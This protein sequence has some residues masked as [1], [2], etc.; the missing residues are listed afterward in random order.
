MPCPTALQEGAPE[1][2]G[3][4]TAA[5]VK[6]DA[7]PDAVGPPAQNEHLR[8]SERGQSAACLG[9]LFFQALQSAACTG[10]ELHLSR[11]VRTR[12]FSM[13]MLAGQAGLLDLL[14]QPGAG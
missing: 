3:G 12:C 4:M 11:S 14:L 8:S 10:R 2:K 6:L 7:L 13:C 1:C 9:L 5:V